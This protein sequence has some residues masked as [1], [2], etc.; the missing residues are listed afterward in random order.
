MKATIFQFQLYF[1]EVTKVIII[2][3]IFT[4]MIFDHGQLSNSHHSFKCL[5]ST[6]VWQDH[7][8]QDRDFEMVLFLETYL[9]SKLLCTDSQRSFSSSELKH[10]PGVTSSY[11]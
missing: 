3:K 7:S 5:L 8:T 1:V 11:T 10:L 6:L 9:L 2:L 4:P